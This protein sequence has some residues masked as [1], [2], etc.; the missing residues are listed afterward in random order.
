MIK[1]IAFLLFTVGLTLSLYSAQETAQSAKKILKVSLNEAI[2]PVTEKYM[3]R[4]LTEAKEKGFGTVLFTLDT[5]GGLLD[6]TREIVKMLLA[7]DD[8]GIDTIVYVYPQGSRAGS[9]GVFITLAAKY[10]AMS[11]GCNI[12][13]AHPVFM[14]EGGGKDDEGVNKNIETLLQKVENDTVAFIQSICLKRGRNVEWATLAVKESVSITADE[15]LKKGVI[16]HIAD[17]ETDLLKKIYGA[18]TAIEIIPFEKSWA[19]SLLSVLANPNL[20]YIFLSLGMLG[21]FIEI[22]HPGVIFPGALG[23][24]LLILGL[25]SNSVLPINFAGVAFMALTFVLL[26]LEVFITSYGLL[27]IGAGISFIVGSAMLFD[28]PLPFLRVSVWIIVGVAISFAALIVLGFIF[29]FPAIRNRT[30]SGHEGMN[31]EIGEAIRD[32]EGGKG[33]IR[34]H[35]E[36]WSAFSDE[37]IKEDDEVVVER[38]DGLKAFVKKK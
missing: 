23:A 38:I 8:D 25:F 6:T 15:A 29:V 32:F 26:V 24:I 36:I 27:S 30:V 20:A 35:G 19:E 37:M 7:A 33:K 16:D 1:R 2:T 21:I 14:Q 28:S 17:N 12:G 22:L 13:A 3:S 10:A 31:G 5:P 18:D 4:A 11:P 34:L 9:A